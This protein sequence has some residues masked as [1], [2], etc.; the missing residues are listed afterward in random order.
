MKK[1]LI[2]LLV[3]AIITVMIVLNIYKN[4]DT[5]SLVDLAS[6]KAVTIKAVTIGTGDVSPYVTAHGRVEEIN[7][8]QVF[9]DTPL[10]VLKIFVN[11]NDHAEQGKRLVEL[12]TSTLTDELNKLKVQRRFKP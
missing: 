2:G 6:R 12:D 11:K 7:R 4:T 8:A 10:R 1:V 5:D 3:I 9:F